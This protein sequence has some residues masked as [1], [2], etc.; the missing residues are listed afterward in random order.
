[1]AK[2]ALLFGAALTVLG[3]FGYLGGAPTEDVAGKTLTTSANG[4]E[5]KP[6]DASSSAG[7]DAETKK[8]V[9][10]TALIPSLFGVLLLICGTLGLDEKMRKH[11][12]HAAAGIALIGCL[13]AGG[14]VAMKIP[15]MIQGSASRASWFVLIMAILCGIYVVLSIQSFRN[16]RR[17]RMADQRS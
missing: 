1:M 6:V 5:G 16:A 4:T 7:S 10:P 12:M 9:S 13:L 14:R 2:W 11:A 3:I 15:D 17:Q 8:G